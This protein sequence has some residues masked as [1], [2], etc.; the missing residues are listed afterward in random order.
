MI[1]GAGCEMLEK[2]ESYELMMLIGTPNRSTGNCVVSQI[3]GFTVIFVF[4][5]D[6]SRLSVTSIGREESTP[7]NAA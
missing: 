2:R 5:G 3:A 6:R 1:P 7:L 4:N